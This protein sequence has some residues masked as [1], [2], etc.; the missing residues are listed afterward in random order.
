M[1]MKI[2]AIAIATL[3]VVIVLGGVLMPILD[4]ATA[5]NE[6]F[7]NEGLWRMSENSNGNV[8]Q[9][10]N[11][12]KTWTLNGEV[13][14]TDSTSSVKANSGVVVLDDLSVRANGWIRGHNLSG[15]STTT[16]VTNAND[17]IVITGNGLSGSGTYAMQG[18]GADPDGNY[19]MTPYNSSVYML[20]DSP[21][22]ATGVSEFTG[23]S[24]FIVHMEGTINDGVT[25]TVS[26]IRNG[27]ALTDISVTNVKINSAEVDGYK[28]L[29]KLTG[30][31][32]DVAFTSQNG[33][34]D[35]VSESGSISYSS[36]VVPYKV[37]AEKSIHFTDNQNA[38]F[39]AIPVLVIAALLIAV[40][41]LVIRSRQF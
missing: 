23:G 14:I 6:T 3:V 4:D 38:I 5:V 31:T 10:N 37:T 27:N 22:Y 7:T 19:L 24:R 26:S 8:Y 36:Y 20:G 16:V 17:E 12:D 35:P 15:N 30:I 13:I 11:T 29:Y 34:N 18:Y 25:V 40:A 21:I 33:E 28:N 2:P 39:A 1:E 32:A 41:L 9:F